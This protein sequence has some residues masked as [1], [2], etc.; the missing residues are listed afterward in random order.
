MTLENA[1]LVMKNTNNVFEELGFDAEEAASLKIRADLILELKKYI[2]AQGWSSQEAADFFGESKENI[3]YLING[4]MSKF[5]IDR[6]VNLLVRA[7]MKV[8]FEV[9]FKRK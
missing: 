1:Q 7:G 5:T 8:E 2:Q 6:L 9:A 3:I 4:K